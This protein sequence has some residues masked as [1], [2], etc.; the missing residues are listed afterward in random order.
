MEFD[1]HM[2]SATKQGYALRADRQVLAVEAMGDERTWIDGDGVDGY[3]DARD[4][5]AI[6]R[7]VFSGKGQ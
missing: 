5:A 4:A 2:M 1:V 7:R 3:S 6:C